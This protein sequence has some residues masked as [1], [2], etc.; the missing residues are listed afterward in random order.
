MELEFVRPPRPFFPA[1]QPPGQSKFPEEDIEMK[2][3]EWFLACAFFLTAALLTS[4]A[5]RTA[6]SANGTDTALNG[7]WKVDAAQ[8]KF[9]PKPYAF[10]ISEGWYHCTTC[11]PEIVVKADGTD[12]AVPN[13]PYDT[14]SVKAVDDQTIQAI[15][16]KDGKVLFD[17][18][19]TV[20]KDGKMLTLKETSHPED[21]SAPVT[22]EVMY[23]R[24]GLVPMGVQPAS[25]DWQ[26]LKFNQSSNGL[27]FTYKVNGDEVTMT[28]PT[29][30]TFTAK[31][32]GTDTPVK[33]AYGFDTI[34]LKKAG[35][36]TIE[37][38]EKRNGTV[39][40]VS[41]ITVHGRIMTIEDTS[42]PSDRTS[43]FTAHKVG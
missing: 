7:T 31:L 6:P 22:T 17:E 28:D 1:C 3:L 23:K 11:T 18:T 33:G 12:Q 42:K 34:S 38:T 2:K 15:G 13:E 14:L 4:A 30:E 5:T 36:G 10:Y 21:G 32:D 26:V 29:G 19:R 9:S 40:D 41:K 27:T 25:G 35:P 20:S 43:T 37:E 8:T 24:A 39:V 16:K